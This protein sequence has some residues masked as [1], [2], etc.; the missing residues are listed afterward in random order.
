VVEVVEEQILALD[1]LVDRV[2]VVNKVVLL[3]QVI[4][5]L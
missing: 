2:E 4:H 3:V 1:V 5:L